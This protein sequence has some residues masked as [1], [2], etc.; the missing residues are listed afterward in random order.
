MNSLGE[1][2]IVERLLHLDGLVGV[3]K[4]VHVGRHGGTEITAEVS[5]TVM[6]C[7]YVPW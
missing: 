5:D 6:L 2:I 7:A 4:S 3:N 1:G